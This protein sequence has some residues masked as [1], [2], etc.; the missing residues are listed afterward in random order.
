MGLL[1]QGKWVDE[2]YDTASTT[3]HFVRSESHFRH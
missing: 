2:W 3:G 1:V